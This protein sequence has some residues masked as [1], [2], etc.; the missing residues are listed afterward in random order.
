MARYAEVEIVKLN[1]LANSS[2]PLPGCCCRHKRNASQMKTGI[3]NS[4]NTIRQSI[5]S[6]T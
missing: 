3:I 2:M 4:V 6:I 1:R 5:A